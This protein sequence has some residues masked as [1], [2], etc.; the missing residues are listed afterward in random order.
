VD[1]TYRVLF[2]DNPLAPVAVPKPAHFDAIDLDRTIEIYKKEFGTAD[3][4]HFFITG[5][6]DDAQL[7]PLMETYLASLPAANKA[8][9]FKDNGVRPVYGKQTVKFRKGSEPK[10]MIL[11]LYHGEAP[12]TEEFELRAQALAEILNIRVIEELREK[13]GGIYGGG[14]SASVEKEPYANYTMVLQ[15][16]CGPENVDKLLEAAHKEVENLKAKGPDAKD[17]AKVKN[18]WHEQHRTKVKENRYWSDKMES[19]L[20]WGMDRKT[21]LDYDNWI[22]KL[23]PADIQA[24]AKQIF[25]GKNEF[26]AILYPES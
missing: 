20:F 12:Y 11:A 24:T 22:D 2:R 7:A 18:Q 3:G 8:P 14:Y 9:N 19:V 26:I 5:N 16:P 17:L 23:T 6:V 25:D 4:Y 1:T 10:S 15:L 21:V 13:M